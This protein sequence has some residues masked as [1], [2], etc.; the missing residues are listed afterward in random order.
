MNWIMRDTYMLSDPP[1]FA[2]NKATVNGRICYMAVKLGTP[3]PRRA[4]D[5]PEPRG[6]D[7]SEILHVERN[8]DPWDE[9]A[10]KAALGRCKDACAACEVPADV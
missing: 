6:W 2:I 7:G 3:W 9:P 8:L 1:G 4:G 5:P 10:R